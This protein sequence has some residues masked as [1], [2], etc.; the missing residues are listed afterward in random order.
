[1]DNGPVV[2]DG[3]ADQA[4]ELLG[5]HKPSGPLR[6]NKYS[7]FEGGTR[8]PFIVTWPENIRKGQISEALVSQ[9]D[10]F[11][12]FA[13]LLN[14]TLPKGACPDSRGHWSSLVGEDNVGCPYVIEQ[15]LW[16]V[17]SVRTLDWKYIEPSNGNSYMQLTN[18]E[19]GNNPEP[20]L[21]NMEQS[22]EEIN[23]ASQHPEIVEQLQSILKQER[24][25]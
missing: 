16:N 7:S 1:S 21:Y 10:L 25:K 5:N 14:A 9:I 6:G 11:Q 22:F 12:S 13:Q 2:D 17:L 3:Y 4:V 18:I 15:N 23:I 24:S 20:Q 19:T 8:V